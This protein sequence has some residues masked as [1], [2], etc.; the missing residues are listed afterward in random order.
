MKTSVEVTNMHVYA[1]H[2]VFEQERRVGNAFSVTV[3]VDYPFEAAMMNDSLDDTVSYA[4][5]CSIIKAE[6]AIPSKL[7]ENAAWR[8]CSRLK[9][10]YPQISGGYIKI[11]KI[12]PPVEA[13]LDGCS[14]IIEW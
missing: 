9:E 2:G 3:R 1:Y 7:I 11:T 4:D 8:I 10:S 12:K 5:I 6:M 14:V 13:Q